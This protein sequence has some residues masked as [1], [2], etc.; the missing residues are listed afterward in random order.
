MSIRQFS[1]P[2]DGLRVTDLV[3]LPYFQTV[4]IFEPCVRNLDPGKF[5]IRNIYG[6]KIS[7]VTV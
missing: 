7:Q 1:H 6:T 3:L 5:E 4:E 2:K